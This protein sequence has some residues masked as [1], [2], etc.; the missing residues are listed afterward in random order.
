MFS[1]FDMHLAMLED[2]TLK[3]KITEVIRD[4]CV[5]AEWAVKVVT[6]EY[7]AR[8]RAIPDEHFRDR[9]ID[10]ED[11]ADQ[12]QSALGGGRH[13]VRL[14][15]DSVI[16]AKELR[17][18]TLSEFAARRPNAVVTEG[19]G[20]TSHTFILAREL[21][22]PAVTGIKKLMRRISPG[23]VVI[24]DGYNGKVFTNP[25][26][27]TLSQYSERTSGKPEQT[28]SKQ[29]ESFRGPIKTLDGRE[30]TIRAN[31]DI[32][33]GYQKAKTLGARGIGLYRS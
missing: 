22:I 17:P 20:W 19:G 13:P 2:S 18:S 4:E 3:E 32:A 11:I 1:I 5:N 30:I 7:I 8:Y 15:S 23:D 9:Y 21:G 10:L 14:A 33:A 12:L 27:Q 6:D 29:T 24:V 26:P 31:L 28:S 25:S 16:A